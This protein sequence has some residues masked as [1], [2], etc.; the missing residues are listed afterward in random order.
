MGAL[1]DQHVHPDQ[2]TLASSTCNARAVKSGVVY[3]RDD[4]TL[5]VPPAVAIRHLVSGHVEGTL[6]AR[7]GSG[8]CGGAVGVDDGAGGEDPGIEELDAAGAGGAK[9]RLAASLDDRAGADPVL[10]EQAGRG[11]GVGQL[12]GAPDEDVAAFGL[13]QSADLVEQVCALRGALGA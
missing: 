13:L 8:G 11:E 2:L 1:D 4:A 9:Q 12:A 6:M 3:N 10:V 7:F 5:R